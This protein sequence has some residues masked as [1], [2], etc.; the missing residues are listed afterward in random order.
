MKYKAVIFDLFGTLVDKFPID[1]SINILKQMAVVLDVS[2]R[3]LVKLWFETFDE[4]HGGD[5]K[6]LREDINYVCGKLG[7]YP[8]D[9][10][11]RHAAQINLDYVAKSIKPRPSAVETLT[12]LREHGYKVGLISNWSDE[13]PTV[14]NDIP[15]SRLFDVAVFS[16]RVGSMKPDSRIYLLA[17]EQLEVKP[18][19]CIY[20]GDGDSKELKGAE[21]VG[22]HPVLINA[23]GEDSEHPANIEAEEWKGERITSLAEIKTLLG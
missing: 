2:A 5:F 15:L 14:W 19:E 18:E 11:V 8:D 13:V 10:K 21:L 9:K 16:C 23:N 7:A 3:D 17:A 6:N 20:I 22:M 4:R 12:C 1:E